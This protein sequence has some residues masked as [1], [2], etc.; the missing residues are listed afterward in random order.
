M[1]LQGLSFSQAVDAVLKK[2]LHSLELD[3]RCVELAAFALAFAA[4]RIGTSSSFRQLPPLNLACSGLSINVDKNEWLKLA[5]SDKLLIYQLDQLYMLFENAPILGSLVNSNKQSSRGSQSLFLIDWNSIQS[6]LFDVLAS[7][8]KEEQKELGVVAQGLAKAANLMMEKYYWVITNVP[9]LARNRHG[10]ILKKYC[11]M[12]YKEAKPDLATVF[13]DRCLEFCGIGG[14]VSVVMPQNWLFLTSYSKFREKLLKKD[15][16]RILLY[17]GSGAFE[18]ISGE[19]VKAILLSIN[20]GNPS[21]ESVGLFGQTGVK[22]HEMYGLDVF[23]QRTAREKEECLFNTEIKAIDQ[24]KRMTNPDMRIIISETSKGNIF[25][26][27]VVSMRGIVSGDNDRWVRKYWEIPVL[28]EGWKTLQSTPQTTKYFSGKEHIIDWRNLGRGMLRPGFSN[29]TYKRKG[30][31]IGQMNVLPATFY[32]GSLYDN[33]TGALVPHNP[34]HLPAIWCYYSSSE[35]NK[36]VRKVDQ[37]LKVT[38]ATLVKVLFDLQYWQKIADEKYPNGLPK[39]YSQDPTQ[40][41]F[42]GHPADSEHPLQVAVARLLG[43]KWPAELDEKMELSE[44]P[45][46]G[47]INAGNSIHL[48]I[49]T[50]LCAFHPYAANSLHHPGY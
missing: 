29:K 36:E 3:P 34:D 16:W 1:E 46:T 21:A 30:V 31:A 4:W 6:L 50:A 17:L 44:E 35:Y 39:P 42:H 8:E 2:N 7:A 13:L 28:Y 40:W 43:Y 9:Y 38:N 14:N 20:R 41:I 22:S 10:D 5:G 27:F 45:D 25:E 11:D 23:P 24:Q 19:V 12:N 33:N 47:S 32:D 37:K 49:T 26:N 48:R 18:T 15:T